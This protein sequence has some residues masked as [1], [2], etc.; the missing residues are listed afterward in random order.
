MWPR[1]HFTR[2]Q[3]QVPTRRGS[4]KDQLLTREKP[5][6]LYQMKSNPDDLFSQVSQ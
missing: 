1:I 5:D 3:R 6:K 2:Q 4:N